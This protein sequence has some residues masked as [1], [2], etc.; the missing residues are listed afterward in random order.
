MDDFGDIG[1]EPGEQDMMVSSTA[2]LFNL[3]TLCCSYYSS[4]CDVQYVMPAYWIDVFPE[5]GRPC[6]M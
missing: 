5:Q 2:V 4:M 1:D 3:Q 6:I